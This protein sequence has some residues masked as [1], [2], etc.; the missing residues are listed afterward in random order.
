MT[1]W[2]GVQVPGHNAGNTVDVD[3]FCWLAEALL[4]PNP[5]LI[6]RPVKMP[7]HTRV[8]RFK[9]IVRAIAPVQV[10]IY[11]HTDNGSSRDHSHV[12]CMHAH[13][14]GLAQTKG[15]SEEGGCTHGNC[16]THWR[17]SQ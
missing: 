11:I 12:T 1:L 6:L 13:G 3:T 16:R 17:G 15:V 9:A 8:G 4:S 7:K 10:P 5:D 2:Y 14:A